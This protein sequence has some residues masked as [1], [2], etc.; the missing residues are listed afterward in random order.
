MSCLN[1][2]AH[3]TLPTQY[4]YSDT[5]HFAH[6]A[7]LFRHTALCPHSTPIQAHCTL[8]T[9]CIYSGTLHFAHIVHLFRHTALCP[10]SASIQAHCTL[11]TQCIYS[12]TLHFAHT[13]HLFRHT[14]LCPHSA[15]IQAHC[16]LTTQCI[17][18]GTLHF[19]HTVHLFRH[20]ALC[21][22]ST[23]MH[24]TMSTL[25]CKVEIQFLNQGYSPLVC[26]AMMSGRHIL[27]FWQDVLPASSRQMT[28]GCHIPQHSTLHSYHLKSHY[29]T[30]SSCFKRVEINC[31]LRIHV[32]WTA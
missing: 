2:Q 28:T 4:I 10:H 20:T 18:S 15:S 25:F 30:K 23:S 7:H 22:H 11:P 24:F 13:A 19:A 9:Q 21:P 12:G 5:L 8:P 32:F 3:C 17:Y 16:T 1:I 6:T 27:L 31:C 26:D 29:P 14:A